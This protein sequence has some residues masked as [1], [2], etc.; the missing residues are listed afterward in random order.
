ME[1]YEEAIEMIISDK[2]CDKKEILVNDILNKRPD[3]RTKC[4]ELFKQYGK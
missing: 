4:D 2:D 1:K 3:L